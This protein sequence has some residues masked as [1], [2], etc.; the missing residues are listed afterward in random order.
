MRLLEGGLINKVDRAKDEL[1]LMI[2]VKRRR[3]LIVYVDLMVEKVQIVE[4]SG[5]NNIGPS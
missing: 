1:K 5:V 4:K 2:R 3:D